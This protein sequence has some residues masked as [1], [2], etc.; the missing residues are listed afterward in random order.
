MIFVPPRILII[1]DNVNLAENIAE[2]LQMDGYLTDVA[3]TGAEALEK[4][5]PRSP[6]VVIADYRLPDTTGPALLR[7][8]R[9]TGSIAHAVVISAYTDDD[10]IADAMR[11]GARFVAKPVDLAV[12]SR[13]IRDGEGPV[14]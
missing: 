7:R 4:A 2:F 12:L 1:D 9:K 13:V 8:L 14:Q 10:T 3:A 11:A 6:D 5:M